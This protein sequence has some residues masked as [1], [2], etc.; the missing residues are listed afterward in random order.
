MALVVQKFGGTSVGTVE[1]IRHVATI[2]AREVREKGNKVAVVVSAM[3]GITDQLVGLANNFNTSTNE[4]AQ[5][6]DAVISSG[7]NVSAGLLALALCELGLKARSWQGWQV[8]IITDEHF[9]KARVKEVDSCKLVECIE[10]GVIPIITGFQGIYNSRVATLGRGGS[11]TTAAA[12]AAALKADRCDI[13]TDV[14]GVF[15]A[16]PRVVAKARK[17]DKITYSEMLE[18]ASSGAKVL[19]PR[20]VEIAWKYGL[21]MQVLSSLNDTPGTLLVNEDEIMEDH[22]ITGITGSSNICT[23]VLSKVN[24]DSLSQAKIFEGLKAANVNVDMIVQNYSNDN[25]EH[26]MTLTIPKNESDVAH[27]AFSEMT[28]VYFSGFNANDNIAKISITGIGMKS[29]A[30][31]AQKMFHILADKGINILV[32]STSDIKISVLIPSE[33]MELAMRSLHTAFELD[34]EKISNEVN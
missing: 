30:G 8:P 26:N 28:G 20:A 10:S 13:Y 23:Y 33:Y 12:I 34:N 29:S 2:V 15:T 24:T 16:D 5:E 6:Y 32:I 9:T 7:E 4:G 14:E 21:R 31:I 25:L 22:K 18:M 19:H 11:D 27:K 3:S 17:L 1:R